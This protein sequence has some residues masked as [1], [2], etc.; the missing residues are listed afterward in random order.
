MPGLIKNFLKFF[1]VRL[2][3]FNRFPTCKRCLRQQPDKLLLLACSSNIKK[4]KSIKWKSKKKTII[5]LIN[6]FSIFIH[7]LD[8]WF[9]S[10]FKFST[11]MLTSLFSCW[12]KFKSFSRLLSFFSNSSTLGD[13]SV[14]LFVPVASITSPKRLKVVEFWEP[15]LDFLFCCCSFMDWDG[16]GEANESR[17]F[18][19]FWNV[20]FPVG[21]CGVLPNEIKLSTFDSSTD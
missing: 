14:E 13:C 17:S 9:N 6:S 5:T 20:S 12:S 16:S 11:F 18:V 4:Y 2:F 7:S 8:L 21:R 3:Y 15:V 1:P 10:F 19:L